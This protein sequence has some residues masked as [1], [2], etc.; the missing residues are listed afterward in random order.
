[1]NLNK[2]GMFLFFACFAL[3]MS[4][5]NTR[6]TAGGAEA[7]ASASAPGTEPVFGYPV[8]GEPW[9]FVKCGFVN[10]SVPAGLEGSTWGVGSVAIDG[11]R[12]RDFIVYQGGREVDKNGLKDE[13]GRLAFDIKVRFAWRPNTRSELRVELVEAKELIAGTADWIA[14]T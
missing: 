4:C 11:A 1:M 8:A 13:A 3:L 5:G 10:L 12:A 2:M 9:Y 7:T 6:T 14:G